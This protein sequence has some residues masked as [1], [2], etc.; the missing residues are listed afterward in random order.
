MAIKK[1]H[2]GLAR[3]KAEKDEGW[4]P[5]AEARFGH[6]LAQ[7]WAELRL[8]EGPKLRAI[9]TARFRH[10]DA[11]G[12]SR[13]I[14]YAALDLPP[15]DEMDLAGYWV[16]DLGSRLH[17][18]WQVELRDIYGNNCEIE[19]VVGED[20]TAGHVD[21]LV[22]LHDPVLR[23]IAIECKSVGGYAFQLAIGARGTAEG[24]R[25]SAVVQTALNAYYAE[26][27]EAVV[28]YWARDAISVQ[29]AERKGISNVGRFVAEWTMAPEVF[30]PIAE[31]EIARVKAIVAL[32][33][34]GML[35]A[36][37]LPELG[38]NRTIVRPRDGSWVETNAEG[39]TTNAGTWFACGYCRYQTLCCDTAPGRQPIPEE[40]GVTPPVQEEDHA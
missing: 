15:S 5:D 37:K 25:Q 22:S 23:L 14:A 39:V 19:V 9:E 18:Q 33:D 28:I 10:S 27:H 40:W 7:R 17:E 24:P 21:A 8:A 32:L 11:N 20:P 1:F 3:P 36:R 34:E 31:A 35:P 16:T 26:A 13:M 38:N 29:M 4:R 30:I 2:D 12:C 6:I